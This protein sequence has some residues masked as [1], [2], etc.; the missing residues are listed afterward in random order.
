MSTGGEQYAEFI[1]AD[2]DAERERRKY[3]DERGASIVS[4]ASALA[5]AVFAIGALV[6]RVQ[7]YKPDDLTVAALLVGLGLFAAAAF[8]GLAASRTIKYDVT[9]PA[10]YKDMVMTKR[11]GDSEDQARRIVAHRNRVTLVSL[12]AINSKKGR[13]LPLA[14]WAQI[15][16]AVA[17]LIAVGNALATA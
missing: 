11:W 6:T 15:A 4:T 14:F 16:A 17:L 5:T 8:C 12:R 10:V 7:G 1:K 2:L 9:D 3:I 13:W